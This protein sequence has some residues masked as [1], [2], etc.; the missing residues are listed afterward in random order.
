M[1]FE[2]WYDTHYGTEEEKE[3][4]TASAATAEFDPNRLDYSPTGD[5]VERAVGSVFQSVRDAP[6]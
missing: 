4:A 2:E 5:D 3:R 6:G 1:S